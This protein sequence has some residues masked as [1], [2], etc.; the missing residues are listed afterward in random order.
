MNKGAIAYLLTLTIQ[1]QF[2]FSLLTLMLS[3]QFRFKK[4]KLRLLAAHP[5]SAFLPSGLKKV[6]VV[7]GETGLSKA[8]IPALNSHSGWNP[9]FAN[10]TV[11]FYGKV[12]SCSN[13]GRKNK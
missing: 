12:C 8:T 4:R 7:A 9:L 3:R 1:L 13:V 11:E 10:W 2:V 6:G 5:T